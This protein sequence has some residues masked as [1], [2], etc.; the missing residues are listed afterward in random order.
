MLKPLCLMLFCCLP[1]LAYAQS[2]SSSFPA[3]KRNG[4]APLAA[5][6]TEEEKPSVTSDVKAVES[7]TLT[8][9]EAKEGQEL[10]IEQANKLNQR[11]RLAQKII[12]AGEGS[13]DAL[14]LAYRERDRVLAEMR[15][16]EGKSQKFVARVR[17]RTGCTECG[18]FD[19]EKNVILKSAP[20][21]KK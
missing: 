9:D 3:I 20:S 21:E 4:Q 7:A 17:Q 5:K 13:S 8:P 18:Y 11:S 10:L 12:D 19:F 6:V 2:V 14:L 16:L 1:A 15:E